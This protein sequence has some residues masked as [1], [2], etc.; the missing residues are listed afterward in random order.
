MRS[1]PWRRSASEGQPKVS[2][3][4]RTFLSFGL[5]PSPKMLLIRRPVCFCSAKA[6]RESIEVVDR[7]DVPYDFERPSF[8]YSIT[9]VDPVRTPTG[10]FTR[11]Y[12]LEPDPKS[13][14]VP[15]YARF[16]RR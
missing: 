8:L 9:S 4:S 7:C 10:I 11:L 16:D 12:W 3:A 5:T 15:T 6:T 1:R 14:V 2:S 13:D